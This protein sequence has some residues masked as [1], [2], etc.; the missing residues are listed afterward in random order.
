MLVDVWNAVQFGRLCQWTQSP[1]EFWEDLNS[2]CDAKDGRTSSVTKLQSK[3]G[4]TKWRWTSSLVKGAVIV[5][6]PGGEIIVQGTPAQELIE[7]TDR[8]TA[9]L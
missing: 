6:E 1:D 5:R 8:F 4:E 3:P 2:A 7:P 9:S